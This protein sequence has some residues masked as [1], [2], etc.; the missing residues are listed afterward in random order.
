MRPEV[1]LSS[2]AISRISEVLP[3]S[4]AP[5]STVI[6]P[7]GSR[8][9][10]S[11]ICVSAPTSRRTL[12][13]TRP[14]PASFKPSGL[15][16]CERSH[17]SVRRAFPAVRPT[18]ADPN[19][20]SARG[21]PAAPFAGRWL[22]RVRRAGAE[23]RPG[24]DFLSTPANMSRALVSQVRSSQVA[25]TRKPRIAPIGLVHEGF[26][27]GCRKNILAELRSRERRARQHRVMP[28]LQGCIP[29]RPT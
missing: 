5:S 2:P 24:F 18:G 21:S 4:V 22:A 1:G 6:V 28:I 9:V 20:S 8:S 19:S 14:T 25:V 15:P 23:H 26:E 3:E 16:E 7:G 29:L 11:W 13:R 12:S 10:V 17:A 27:V